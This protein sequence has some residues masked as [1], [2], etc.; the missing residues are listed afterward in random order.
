MYASLLMH[1]VVAVSCSSWSLQTLL[2]Q[3]QHWQPLYVAVEM[4]GLLL[5]GWSLDMLRA[6]STT[7]QAL[8]AAPLVQHFE[9]PNVDA[10]TVC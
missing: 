8:Q 1:S 2:S 3:L 9:A 6:I 4:V 7:R 10:Q 5:H